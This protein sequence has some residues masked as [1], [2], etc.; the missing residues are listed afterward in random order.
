MQSFVQDA[1]DDIVSLNQVASPVRQELRSAT[2]ASGREF[3][4]VPAFK[5]R[6]A[7]LLESGGAT[8][9]GIRIRIARNG[10]LAITVT[11]DSQVAATMTFLIV[12]DV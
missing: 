8:V 11:H 5:A 1:I 2:V 9:S 10:L 6:G 7:Y 4:I 3:S 12:G